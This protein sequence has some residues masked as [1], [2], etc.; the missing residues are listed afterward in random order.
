MIT[1]LSK[2]HTILEKGM[3]EFRPFGVDAEGNKIRDASGVTVLA[4]VEC[5]EELVSETRDPQAG[6]EAVLELC[7]RLNERISDRTYHVTPQFLKNVWNSYSYEFVCF[8]GQICND[9]SGDPEFQFRVG[10]RKLISP[11]IQTLG[12]PFSVSQ[13]YRMFPHFGQK[14]SKGSI[15]FSTGAITER[16][17]ILRMSYA[18]H[19]YKQFGPYRKSCALS[20][21]QSAKSALGAFPS[22]IHHLKPATITDRLCIAEGDEHCE[23]EFTWIPKEPSGFL[24]AAAAALLSGAA[25]AYQ[26]L[27]Y[28]EIPLVN[29]AILSLFP[30]ATLW[31]A[32]SARILQGKV[33]SRERVLQEQ[34]TLADARH[35]ELRE[36]SIEQEQAA[37]D[38]KRKVGQLTLLY[39]TGMIVNSTLDRET[40]IDRALDTIKHNLN[41]DRV[42][43]SFFDEE[44]HIS[45]DARLVG[46]P[47]EVAALARSLTT[48]V[49]DSSS[50]E[51]QLLLDGT[52]ILV[53]DLR[54]VWDR[55]HPVSQQLVS[56]T[57]AQ[58]IIAVPL[59]VKHRVIGSLTV[60][61]LRENALSSD[62]LDVMITVAN[63]LAIALEHA[64]AYRQIEEMNIGL[65]DK[66]RERTTALAQANQ[67][68]QTANE[69]LQELDRLK[70]AFVSVASHELRT[71]M[72]SIKSYV[73]NMLDGVTGALTEKQ[74]Q[75]LDRIRYNVDR[76]TRMIGD[77]LDL[78]SIEAGR[79]ELRLE[80]LPVPGFI[81]DIIENLRAISAD[82]AVA[83]E[84]RHQCAS[85][86]IRADR[87]KLA[88]VLTNLIGNAIKFTPP[89]GTIQIA[90]REKDDGF[91]QIC[92]SDTG[93]GIGPEELP[94]VF[95]KFFRGHSTPT[96][97]RGA[98]LGLAIVKSLVELHGGRVWV[99]ST[100]GAGSHFFFT[101]PL[102]RP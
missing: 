40:L 68:L 57:H 2:D 11:I 86:S 87:D 13:I 99:E 84:V 1:L 59:K 77:L 14:Y 24:R 55:L 7:R 56:V 71:P 19:V 25:F 92:V 91:L 62:D 100:P 44:K 46:V 96:D 78:S 34:V 38:L 97:V 74:S 51:G 58:S 35:E 94:R 81:D 30:G 90:T 79:V 98:G 101:L 8:L 45:Y 80:P 61:R 10:E 20:I 43:L 49:V 15:H 66:V 72:T 23:W 63:Q 102:H 6:Q 82:K 93:C 88:Q 50:I 31:L 5:L 26:Y 76:L 21:C 70:S 32:D 39:Q 75:Y 12:R 52:P 85:P 60:D 64:A 29:A 73:E 18:D 65:E 27:R 41:F 17:A 3:M 67:E 4:N 37:V 47:E 69:R 53:K 22:L 16:S 9:L 54:Q 83:L 33:L 48:P 95:E 28:P 42:M 36:A 89:G